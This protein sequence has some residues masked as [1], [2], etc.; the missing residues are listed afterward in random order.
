M[1]TRL[2]TLAIAI[3][4][5]AAGLAGAGA[6]SCSSGADAECMTT[7]RYFAQ[8]V[9]G[10]T[11]SKKCI[12]CH[13]LYGL[14]KTSTFILQDESNPDFISHNLAIVAGVAEL[15]K[16][17]ESLLL[18]KARGDLSH[19]GGAQV[20]EG[21]DD[22]AALEEL[23]QRLREPEAC[24]GASVTTSVIQYAELLE[25]VPTLRKAS[26]SLLS[27]WP[28]EAEEEKVRAEGEAGFDAVLRGMMK[29]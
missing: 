20:N 2:S 21:D 19:G 13:T 29:E 3:P 9:W 7:T 22:Y 1:K 18:Q 6:L 23:V 8:R 5:A 17:G 27:R 10:P 16:G 11:I 15:D 25:W 26:M 12:N 24:E 4:L 28:T 14:A